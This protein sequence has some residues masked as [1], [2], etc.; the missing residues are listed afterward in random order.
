MKVFL[1]VCK[2]WLFLFCILRSLRFKSFITTNNHFHSFQQQNVQHENQMLNLGFKKP[3]NSTDQK[4][5]NN[6]K[7]E[8]QIS[9]LCQTVELLLGKLGWRRIDDFSPHKTKKSCLLITIQ[10]KT[11]FKPFFTVFR[12]NLSISVI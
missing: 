1:E 12:G 8:M 7:N 5:M 6:K 4:K 2:L 10:I 3:M 11:S 9:Q